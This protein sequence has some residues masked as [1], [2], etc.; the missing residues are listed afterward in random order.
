[1]PNT[2]VARRGGI[3]AVQRFRVRAA[4]EVGSAA[5]ADSGPALLQGE[6]HI[7]ESGAGDLGPFPAVRG[8]G[9]CRDVGKG[10]VQLGQFEAP[11]SSRVE[12]S[13]RGWPRPGS[14]V[15]VRPCKEAFE[16]LRRR[17]CCG[18]GR[19]PVR[20]GQRSTPRDQGDLVFAWTAEKVITSMAVARVS[21]ES[22]GLATALSRGMR[23]GMTSRHHGPPR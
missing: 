2:P 17:A 19:C 16:I 1:M 10:R 13:A 6:T 23:A 4:S 12:V 15:L 7:A 14:R 9:G 8:Q 18:A 11:L 22:S 3:A 20:S 5:S 21:D